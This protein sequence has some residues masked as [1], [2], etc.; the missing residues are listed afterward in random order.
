[1]ES[2]A[3]NACLRSGKNVMSVMLM[4]SAAFPIA[5]ETVERL[6]KMS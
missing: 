5:V 2:N 1:M 4:L 6:S 3:S